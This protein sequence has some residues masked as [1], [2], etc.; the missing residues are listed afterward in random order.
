[1][2]TLD[3]FKHFLRES[4]R[5]RQTRYCKN[6]QVTV[7]DDHPENDGHTESEYVSSIMLW[8]GVGRIML[9]AHFDLDTAAAW[10]SKGMQVEE[11]ELA[12]HLAIDF[13]REFSNLHGGYLRGIFEGSGIPLRMSLPFVASGQ[14]PAFP[15]L[16]ESTTQRITW[17]LSDGIRDITCTA[18]VE[19]ADE[20]ALRRVR[21]ILEQALK[22]EI[23]QLLHGEGGE[24]EFL[25]DDEKQP[26]NAA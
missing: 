6:M 4:S 16:E 15:P 14:D 10:A 5:L 20:A 1:M 12:D 18:E 7:I 24:V 22:E 25:F 9:K 11:S 13:F 19:V 3:F 23:R 21:P 8:G 17:K 26:S 2:E